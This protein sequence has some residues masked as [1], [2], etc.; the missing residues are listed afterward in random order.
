MF[1]VVGLVF[2]QDPQ[3][4]PLIPDQGAVEQFASA[5]ADPPLHDRVRSGGLYRALENADVRG[6]E[7]LVEDSGELGVAVTDQ[8]L[9]RLKLA[10]LSGSK[11]RPI[12][13]T[14]GD[15]RGM[16]VGHD[17]QPCPFACSI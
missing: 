11:S 12:P 1:V 10:V 16:A 9:D 15:G 17:D 3:E 8:E 13:V 7:D 2:S 4:V 6:I 14:W 5:S